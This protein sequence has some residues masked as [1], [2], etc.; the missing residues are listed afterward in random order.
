MF[1][2]FPSVRVFLCTNQ[3]I[4]SGARWWS[5]EFFLKDMESETESRGT[6]PS[7]IQEDMDLKD[8]PDKLGYRSSYFGMLNFS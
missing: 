2:V 7:Y 6:L 4:V 8:D 1:P 3:N 5:G